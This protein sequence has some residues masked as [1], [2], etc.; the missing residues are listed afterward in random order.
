MAALAGIGAL[1]V[2]LVGA[3]SLAKRSSARTVKPAVVEEE[4]HVPIPTSFLPPAEPWIEPRGGARRGAAVS[5]PGLLNRY[6]VGFANETALPEYRDQDDWQLDCGVMGGPCP[7]GV[8]APPLT[9]EH[10]IE[11]VGQLGD[12]VSDP[13]ASRRSM[14]VEI[15]EDPVPT[16]TYADYGLG[17][18][19]PQES[20]FY[21][22]R[23]TRS[24]TDKEF[25]GAR[26][27][28]AERGHK[29]PSYLFHT[30]QDLNGKE[31]NRP[32]DDHTMDWGQLGEGEAEADWSGGAVSARTPDVRLLSLNRSQT[33]A[34]STRPDEEKKFLP[35]TAN[36]GGFG[37]PAAESDIYFGA[38]RER[39]YDGF[40]SV[41]GAGT[42]G[43][44]SESAGVYLPAKGRNPQVYAPYSG[45]A[46]MP[47]RSFAAAGMQ[48]GR[49]NQRI[50][51]EMPIGG[52][53]GAGG[54]GG[55]RVAAGL[56]V[57]P[58]LEH[59]RRNIGVRFDLSGKEEAV[60]G[61]LDTKGI[62]AFSIGANAGP[63]VNPA[64]GGYM[65]RSRVREK[66]FAESVYGVGMMGGSG[67]I[68]FDDVARKGAKLPQGDG[69]RKDFKSIGGGL[70]AWC[71]SGEPI[72]HRRRAIFTP[73]GAGS[74][75]AG[76]GAGGYAS[77]PMG[78]F[79]VHGNA[80]IGT[81]GATYSAE[82]REEEDVGE[83]REGELYRNIV[84][85][86]TEEALDDVFGVEHS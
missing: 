30:Q 67:P 61:V 60:P 54:A 79:S 13:N 33:F 34:T 68:R 52:L 83:A 64:D 31:V 65:R 42:R 10:L 32:R 19:E 20:S 73:S 38:R 28:D 4:S 17:Y 15:N 63:E 77:A 50:D 6:G 51:F 70:S 35:P 76:G 26:D 21:D 59:R 72:S 46:E 1:G 69:A 12:F 47:T 78:H 16:R 5:T 44:P 8:R 3:L 56:E 48:G 24:Q 85:G 25:W 75:A 71:G 14:E 86:R 58:Q 40:G 57:N 45:S 49:M 66:P 82:P 36:R 7:H 41:K 11:S 37:A 27:W 9:G 74:A 18:G 39:A 62:A 22:P 23:G 43:A 80:A 84:L 29:I 2:S 53:D 55:E 81:R